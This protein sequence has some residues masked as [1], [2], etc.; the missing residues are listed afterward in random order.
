MMTLRQQLLAWPVHG[1]HHLV[2]HHLESATIDGIIALALRHATVFDFSR[3]IT[4]W[5]Q[6]NTI[7]SAPLPPPQHNTISYLIPYPTTTPKDHQR[8]ITDQER[9]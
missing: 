7:H 5:L 4:I 9:R 1:D 8:R 3:S 6:S 2:H